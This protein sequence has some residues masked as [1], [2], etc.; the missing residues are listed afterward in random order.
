ML[1]DQN[2][3]SESAGTPRWRLGNAITLA[4]GRND[5]LQPCDYRRRLRSTSVPLPR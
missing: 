4:S 1:N 5:V 3:P 2:A